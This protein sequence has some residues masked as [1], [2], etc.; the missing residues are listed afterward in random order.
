M[1]RSRS[2]SGPMAAYALDV[3]ILATSR[4]T[5]WTKC[6]L[7][8]SKLT[9]RRSSFGNPP[10]VSFAAAGF[11]DYDSNT[12]PYGNSYSSSSKASTIY[13]P[14]SSSTP[15]GSFA[16]PV[17]S[18]HFGIVG[19]SDALDCNGVEAKIGER[20]GPNKR[21]HV[22]E[23]LPQAPQQQPQAPQPP[24]Q[25][26]QFQA[27][28]RTNRKGQKRYDTPISIR[29]VLQ[30]NKLDIS[31]MDFIAWSPAVCKELKRLCTRVPKK[32]LPKASQ[33]PQA[34]AGSLPQFNFRMPQ[35]TQPMP[36]FPQPMPAYM[37]P[38]QAWQPTMTGAVQN[39]QTNVNQGPATQQ[40]T[41]QP[42]PQTLPGSQSITSFRVAAAQAER[43]TRQLSAMIAVEKA[44]RIPS[45]IFKPE[46]TT[47]LLEKKYT[48]GDQGSDMN[49][50]SM[51]LV[52]F[53]GLQ[54][55]LLE[56]VGFKGL[57]MRTADHRETV[58]EY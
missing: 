44:F 4:N 53:L 8:G 41:Q 7:L 58:L 5:A 45:T 23:P 17:N 47:M 40:S 55:R 14:S 27:E 16:S 24:Q 12:L 48:Q 31:W 32:R 25:P 28:E 9:S 38:P 33:Q 37:M 46:G 56:E 6:S 11:G 54:L 13:T 19:L 18:V 35:F 39:P 15:S 21:A 34:Q 52:R 26:F 10:Q 49:V 2:T 20:S 43:H 50:V 36:A 22:E 30:N 1:A 42:S 29:H 3:V 51:G 57:S